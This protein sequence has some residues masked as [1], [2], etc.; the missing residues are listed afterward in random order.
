MKCNE[1]AGQ[2][3]SYPYGGRELPAL[4]RSRGSLSAYYMANSLTVYNAFKPALT[5]LAFLSLCGLM[6]AYTNPHAMQS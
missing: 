3:H 4:I 2:G 6:N 5:L 1:L